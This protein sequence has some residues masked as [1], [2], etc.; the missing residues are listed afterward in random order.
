[1]VNAV[2]AGVHRLNEGSAPAARPLVIE[3]LD[4][5]GQTDAVLF[6]ICIVAVPTAEAGGQF[7]A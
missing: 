2:P 1:M 6:C 7:A 4:S 5:L 3:D